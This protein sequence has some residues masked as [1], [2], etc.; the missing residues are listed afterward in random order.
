[1]E[2]NEERLTAIKTVIEN[3]EDGLASPLRV[4]TDSG[5]VENQNIADTIK[6][7]EYL[8]KNQAVDSKKNQMKRFGFYRNRYLD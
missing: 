2:T 5:E 1:M 4:K 6:A 7:L 8:K 3:I